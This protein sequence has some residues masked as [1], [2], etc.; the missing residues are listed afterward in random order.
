MERM[1]LDAMAKTRSLGS[2][3]TTRM[4]RTS[5][6]IETKTYLPAEDETEDEGSLLASEDEDW[7]IDHEDMLGDADELWSDTGY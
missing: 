3:S 5:E 2:V 6:R 1:T 7:R 4:R